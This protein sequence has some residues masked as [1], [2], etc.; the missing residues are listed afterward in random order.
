MPTG[1]LA[2]PRRLAAA[3]ETSARLDPLVAALRPLSGAVVARPLWRRLL[4]GAPLGHAAHPLLTDVPI[5]LWLSSTALDLT[6]PRH[7]DAA[8]LLLGLGILAS[9]PAS[10][11]GLADWQSAGPRV[12]RVGALHAVLNTAALAVYGTSWV[13]RRSQHRGLGVTASLAAATILGASAYLG[14]HLTLVLDSPPK[15]TA[16]AG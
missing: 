12:Q 1:H 2:V 9:A 5:G 3:A 15:G 14:G 16:Q 6:G 4:R 13:L 8:D 10:T 7:A 11:T